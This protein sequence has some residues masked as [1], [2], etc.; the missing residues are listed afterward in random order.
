VDYSNIRHNG[1]RYDIADLE[2]ALIIPERDAAIVAK[3][4][5]KA[6]GKSTIAFCCSQKHAERVTK[7]FK[8]EGIAAATYLA[9]TDHDLRAILRE[10]MR[11]GSLKVLCVV[12]VLNEGVDLPFIECLLFLR[13]TE[14][15]RVFFQQLGRGLRRFVGKEYCAVIDFIGNFQNAYRALENLGLEPFEDEGAN[16]ASSSGRSSKA[17]LNLPAG[18]TVEFEERVVD[19]FGLQTLNP[20]F[21][22]RR[23]IARIL[24]HQYRRIERRLGRPPT[25]MEFNRTSGSWAEFLRKLET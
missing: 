5:E 25:K 6:E 8:D 18:C 13:P 3:W 11:V 15:K 24:I 10:K 7:S 1:V 21:A 9:S 19:V 20:A 22:T 14:S 16:L 17:I 12:D 4:R 2:R 23:N